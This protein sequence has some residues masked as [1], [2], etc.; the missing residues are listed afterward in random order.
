MHKHILQLTRGLL[1]FGIPYGGLRTK[2]LEK[3]LRD[4]NAQR[5]NPED[6]EW[7][8]DMDQLIQLLKP[9]SDY[10][11]RLRTQVLALLSPLV[12]EEKVQIITFYENARTNM[13]RMVSF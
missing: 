2:E 3:A 7:C 9:N 8:S 6:Q 5:D 11:A 12:Q 4:I 1:F 10:L 13:A